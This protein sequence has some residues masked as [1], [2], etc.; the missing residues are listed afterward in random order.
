M[1]TFWDTTSPLAVQILQ[2]NEEAQELELYKDNYELLLREINNVE[3]ELSIKEDSLEWLEEAL[4]WEKEDLTVLQEKKILLMK[5]IKALTNML[6]EFPEKH[7]LQETLD[8]EESDLFM[9]N[10]EIQY[11]EWDIECSESDISITQSDIEKIEERLSILYQIQNY[12]E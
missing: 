5:K 12:H 7:D 1:L 6:K 8:D 9:L 3:H 4:E 11:K 2:A 10:N